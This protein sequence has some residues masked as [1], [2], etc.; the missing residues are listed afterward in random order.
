MRSMYR[1]L[2]SRALNNVYVANAFFSI[3][4]YLL[5][6]INSPFLTK[7]V[8]EKMLGT[9]YSVGALANMILMIRAPHMV[10]RL[11]IRKFALFV[12]A[13]DALGIVGMITSTHP[14]W[15]GA[16]FVLHQATVLLMVY[17]LD[18]FLERATQNEIYTGRI[19]SIFLTISNILLVASPLIA[20]IIVTH[21]QSFVPVYFA[22]L[23]FVIPLFFI[24]SLDLPKNGVGSKHVRV[25][26]SLTR[27]WNTANIRGVTL[28]RLVLECFYAWMVIYMAVYLSNYIGFGWE[29]IG[30]LFAIMLLPFVVFELPLGTISDAHANEKEIIIIG[31]GIIAVS[32]A[33]IP[34]LRSPEF[35]KWAALLFTTRVGASFVE[36]GTESYF[37]KHVNA[38]DS[39]VVSIFRLMRPLAYILAPLVALI[40]F[41]GVSL[42]NS[43]F[44]LAVV[45][46]LGLV[47]ALLIKENKIGEQTPH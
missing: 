31:F 42:Q 7:I 4:T 23:M 22:S 19:R 45:V 28:I 2:F 16:S 38:R 20:G 18:L 8:S 30:V 26:E 24:I 14:L 12:L 44:V 33:F 47:P 15:V 25:W 35:L 9:L 1:P 27:V 10:A 21:S 6:Y 39:G 5:L 37:F 32:T 17:T 3:H 29:Q 13:A 40:I 41:S 11:G 34:L 46:V 43:F 36:I